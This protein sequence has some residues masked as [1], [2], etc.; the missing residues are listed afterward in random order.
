MI[1]DGL[2]VIDTIWFQIKIIGSFKVIG[3]VCVQD[4]ISKKI[5][6]YIGPAYGY[7][8][9]RDIRMIVQTGVPCD[10]DFI[11]EWIQRQ[12]EFAHAG[13]DD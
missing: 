13:T 7:N 11:L 10:G 12:K 9:D 3:I 4:T 2:E 5:K 1:I 8:L 6:M